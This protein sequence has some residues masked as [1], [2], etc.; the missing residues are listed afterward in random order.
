MH[1]VP[2]ISRISRVHACLKL[3]PISYRIFTLWFKG[4]LS[5]APRM[6]MTNDVLL[7][8]HVKRGGPGWLVARGK[9][10]EKK[11]K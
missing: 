9:K 3:L 10:E 1:A 8:K 2:L 5:F 7:I 4:L 6:C 11:K